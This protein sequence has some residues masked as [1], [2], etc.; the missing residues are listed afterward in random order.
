M[1]VVY[2][3][4]HMHVDMYI[5]VPLSGVLRLRHDAFLYHSPFYISRESL[6]IDPEHTISAPLVGQLTVRIT[7]LKFFFLF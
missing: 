2:V 4:M 5:Y 6:L 7:Q 1:G 3:C